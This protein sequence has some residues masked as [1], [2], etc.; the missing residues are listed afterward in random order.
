MYFIESTIN[1]LF[2]SQIARKNYLEIN[3]F[4]NLVIVE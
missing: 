3:A 4:P 1:S 2:N